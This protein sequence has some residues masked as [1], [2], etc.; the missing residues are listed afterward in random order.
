VAQARVNTKGDVPI[1]VTDTFSAVNPVPAG[2]TQFFITGAVTNFNHYPQTQQQ[3]ALH[4]AALGTNDVKK[5]CA[6]SDEWQRIFANNLPIMPIV[7]FN[8]LYLMNVHVDGWSW[9][10]DKSPRFETAFWK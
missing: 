3:D 8:D 6:A 2:I 5:I 7:N 1:Y 9:F 4:A 10:P